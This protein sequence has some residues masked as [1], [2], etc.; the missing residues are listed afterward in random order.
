M[1]LGLKNRICTKSLLSGRHRL[2]DFT[3]SAFYRLEDI[4]MLK[5]PTEDVNGDRRRVEIVLNNVVLDWRY[6]KLCVPCYRL[7]SPF[8]LKA[9]DPVILSQIVIVRDP[10]AAAIETLDYPE[11]AVIMERGS[12]TLVPNH[13]EN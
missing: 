4:A 3:I 2:G 9:V 7:F 12:L 10:H 11:S 8:W 5:E 1:G 6:A 13:D